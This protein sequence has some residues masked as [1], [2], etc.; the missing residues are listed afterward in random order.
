VLG[1]YCRQLK[2]FPLETAIRKMTAMPA[3][4]LGLADRGLLKQGHAA[5]VVVFD[6]KT[7]IDKATFS[8]PHQYPEG[9]DTVVVNG[10]AVILGGEHTEVRPGRVLTPQRS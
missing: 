8:A 1:R 3:S 4:Q 7:I 6:F 10:R 2:L 5:D 9:I